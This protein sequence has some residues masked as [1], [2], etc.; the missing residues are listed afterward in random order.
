MNL[1][2]TFFRFSRN[3]EMGRYYNLRVNC[4]ATINNDLISLT[5]WTF[6]EYTVIPTCLLSYATFITSC[7][8]V[9]SYKIRTKL[10]RCLNF[11]SFAFMISMPLV[12]CLVEHD[13]RNSP[14]VC[15]EK[16]P[17]RKIAKKVIKLSILVL[18]S[19]MSGDLL[20]NLLEFR[21]TVLCIPLI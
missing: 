2:Y 14:T 9:F 13:W 1:D 20:R 10:W 11:Q 18:S 15:H 12:K 6:F 4:W 17:Y 3:K 7:F 19:R 5:Q 16:T 8:Y 21:C